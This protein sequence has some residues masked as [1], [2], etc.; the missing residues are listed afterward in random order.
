MKNLFPWLRRCQFPLMM[1]LSVMPMLLTQPQG[2]EA[3]ATRGISVSSTARVMS[4]SSSVAGAASH[5]YSAVSVTV[6]P[7]SQSFTCISSARTA[8][9]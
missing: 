2:V 9:P 6:T 7:H 3:I 5:S 8:G 1:L 4:I